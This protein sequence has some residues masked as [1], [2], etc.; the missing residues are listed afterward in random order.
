MI[1][2]FITGGTFDKEY[3]FITGELYFKDTHLKEMFD[4]GRCTLDIDIKTLM[5]IDSL[6]MTDDDRDIIIHNC[7]KTVYSNIIITHGT[8][9]MVKTAERIA[10]AN[11]K[12][13]TIVLTG[14]MVPY[15]FGT[16]SDGF[17]N[18]GSA[19]AFS[20]ALPE[21]V[22][23]VI[24]FWGNYHFL[25]GQI[26]LE[27]QCGYIQPHSE[28]ERLLKNK[29][30]SQQMNFPED[31][32]YIPIQFH[33]VGNNNGTGYIGEDEVFE[34]LCKL[35]QDFAETELQF[36]FSGTFN[37]INNSAMYD[38]NFPSVPFVVTQLYLDNKNPNAV[39]I[40]I[41]NG[42]SSGNS[43]YYTG[44][45]DI[46]YMDKNYVNQFDV[47]LAHELGHFFSL[48]HP[49]FGWENTEYDPNEPTPTTVTNGNNIYNV[50]YVDRAIN[51]EDSGDFLCGTPAD[52][53]LDWNGGCNYAGG[54]VDPDSVLIDPDEANFMGY[55]SFTNC[56][57]YH[58]SDDQ[59]D[60]IKA[61]YMDRSELNSVSPPSLAAVTDS[62]QLIVPSGNELINF[63]N[64]VNFAWESVENATN[65]L[66]EISR[67]DNFFFSDEIGVVEGPQYTATRL[68]KNKDYYWRV[69]A[70]NK[71]D[72]CATR[73]YSL[74]ET[75]ETGDDV[76]G[77]DELYSNAPEIILS[78]NPI[79]QNN[80][81]VN[82]WLKNS[83]ANT[84]VQ[85]FDIKGQVVFQKEMNQLSKGW[86]TIL[87]GSEMIFQQGVYF[88]HF[89][90]EKF[91]HSK[92][93]VVY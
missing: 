65:Y 69:W 11:I 58:F 91:L 14:A 15:A 68:F 45:A 33:I 59:I 92:K 31:I 49:F 13:K 21:G 89:K 29:A 90:N 36:Y 74:I 62:A 80:V 73:I 2:V 12:N 10:D 84:E 61:D 72:P 16:S 23:L 82:I 9:T 66:I 52:Y 42:L 83:L 77:I 76:T 79:D 38:L 20:Q 60:L 44:G 39:N 56:P 55:Y 57:Q 34:G 24:F 64:E 70:F 78:P 47:I 53:I 63:Y 32:Q 22:L 3:N 26:G 50:E 6:E 1:Q 19:L 25:K 18:L 81:S 28:I 5:M 93:L 7:K 87:E 40:F 48:A 8:D 30:K 27:G 54:A 88:I 86:N 85:I 17:F 67:F 71:A 75:F 37:Y 43:G 4:R 41:G 35:N 46:I 51:C